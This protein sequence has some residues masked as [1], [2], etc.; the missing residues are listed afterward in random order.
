MLSGSSKEQDKTASSPATGESTTPV[1]DTHFGF[2]LNN[3]GRRYCRSQWVVIKDVGEACM[4][5]AEDAMGDGHTLVDYQ[6]LKLATR[7]FDKKGENHVL[8]QGRSCDV[9]KGSLYGKTTAIKV[10]KKNGMDERTSMRHVQHTGGALPSRPRLMSAGG[11][12]RG[13]GTLSAWGA[14]DEFEAEIQMLSR[15]RHPHIVQLFAGSTNGPLRCIVLEYMEG[16]NLFDRL[17]FSEKVRRREVA[18]S[19]RGMGE[20]EGNQKEDECAGERI[21]SSAC[22]GSEKH[23]R[24]R[25]KEE[26][27]LERQMLGWRERLGVVVCITRA[28]QFLHSQHPPILHRDV[29]SANVLLRK[30]ENGHWVAKLCDFGKVYRPKIATERTNS[31]KKPARTA[32]ASSAS[33]IRAVVEWGQGKKDSPQGKKDSPSK[34]KPSV[35]R[36]SHSEVGSWTSANENSLGENS[37]GGTSMGSS[38]LLDSCEGGSMQSSMQSSR[39]RSGDH[40]HNIE[41]IMRRGEAMLLVYEKANDESMQPRLSYAKDGLH[42][43]TIAEHDPFL[44]AIKAMKKGGMMK[45]GGGASSA[46]NLSANGSHPKLATSSKPYVSKIESSNWAEEQDSRERRYRVHYERPKETALEDEKSAEGDKR[47]RQKSDAEGSVGTHGG[48]SMHSIASWQCIS[49]RFLSEEQGSMMSGG[50]MLS[51]H[52]TDMPSTDVPAEAKDVGGDGAGE[53]GGGGDGAGEGDEGESIDSTDGTESTDVAS[54]KEEA[55]ARAQN[56]S[57]ENNNERHTFEAPNPYV[58]MEY[59]TKGHVSEKTDGFALGIVLVELLTDFQPASARDLVDDL[60]GAISVF[61]NGG[62]GERATRPPLCLAEGLERIAT[63][64]CIP[65]LMLYEERTEGK[66]PRYQCIREG[67]QQAKTK[68]AR[69]HARTFLPKNLK[70]SRPFPPRVFELLIKKRQEV[71]V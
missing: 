40:G 56:L 42:P 9:Y 71:W 29:T 4:C 24:S 5:W 41:S 18:A 59:A 69:T 70:K 67:E 64:Q 55:D 65:H 13:K 44:G 46:G 50:S 15:M 33:G 45:S 54:V 10:L 7:N 57:E 6:E 25:V 2:P 28:L 22:S 1:F 68:P 12:G 43:E 31:S 52:T 3:A 63:M 48:A 23:G 39:S 47:A 62:R 21:P 34:S 17:R 66:G 32:R 8:V 38:S 60:S 35:S 49:E 11:M 51:L 20:L 27:E 30:D 58:P 53:G 14:V 26:E 36:R 19:N 37:L 61:A 16:G